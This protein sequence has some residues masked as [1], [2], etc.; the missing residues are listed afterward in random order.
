MTNYVVVGNGVAGLRAAEVIRNSDRNAKVTILSDEPYPFYYRPQ[1][2][3]YIGGL[4]KEA[5]L[6]ARGKDFYEKQKI[7]AILGKRAKAVVP[8]KQQVILEDG[9]KV[10]YDRLLLAPGCRFQLPPWAGSQ[11]SGIFTL[12]TLDDAKEISRAAAKS[13]KALVV[14]EGLFGLEMARGLRER[15]LKVSYL[16]RG[17][18]FWPEMLD[19]V[20]SGLVISHLKSK[21]IEIL[22]GEEVKEVWASNGRVQGV[23]TSKDR[24]ILGQMVGVGIDFRPDVEFLADSKIKLGKGILTDDH[25]RTNFP[26]IFAAGD[27][28]QVFD[29]YRGESVLHFGWQSAWEQG[30]IAG[31]NMAG[32][33]LTYSGRIRA[34]SI[35][36]YGLDFLSLGEGNPQAPGFKG[37]TGDY[38]EMGIYKKLV[39]KENRVVGALLLGSISEASPI[40]DL[41]LNRAEISQVDKKLLMRVFDFYY[42]MSSGL[43]VLCPV[44]K[45]NV[46][47]KEKAKEGD[48]ITCPICGVEFT[49]AKMNGRFRAIR[50]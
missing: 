27:A 16:L 4:A 48:L 8:K 39:L 47:L 5:S 9:K 28:A 13:Q 30:A 38:P 26:N 34:L 3:D 31:A 45:L 20:A 36:I 49:L 35:Q 44:C 21:G 7:T 40:E 42:W 1:L 11:S 14:G 19:E 18:H 22:P 46:Q 41:I 24:L 2:A 43:E 25:L 15:G 29:A 17:E 37:M 32:N 23:M 10:D 50:A 33:D 12:R 6:W